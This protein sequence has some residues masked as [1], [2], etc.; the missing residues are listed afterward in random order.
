MDR[1]RLFGAVS[2]VQSEILKFVKK[3][4]TQGP[5]EE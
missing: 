2:I 1:E 4:F 3:H 5:E